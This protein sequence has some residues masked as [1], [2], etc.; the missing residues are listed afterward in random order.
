[1]MSFFSVNRGIGKKPVDVRNGY[2]IIPLPDRS[3]SGRIKFK[4]GD[5]LR[6]SAKRGT[7]DKGYEQEWTTEVYVVRKVNHGKPVEL[8]KCTYDPSAVYSIEKV[9]DTRTHKGKKQSLVNGRGIRF[10]LQAG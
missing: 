2:F 6:I 9:L 3:V 1:M 4:L 5:H 7:F 8:T 10:L